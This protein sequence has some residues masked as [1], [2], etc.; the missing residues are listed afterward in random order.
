MN[1][2][3]EVAPLTDVDCSL[4]QGWKTKKKSSASGARS[5]SATHTTE[6]LD[7]LQSRQDGGYE[8]DSTTSVGEGHASTPADGVKQ[9]LDAEPPIYTPPPRPFHVCSSRVLPDVHQGTRYPVGRTS[10]L[11]RDGAGHQRATVDA[12]GA[13]RAVL[14]TSTR[15]TTISGKRSLPENF[16]C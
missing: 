5:S 7:D 10:V 2:P 16:V 15:D 4:V 1:H 8:S 14:Q 3:R 9:D 6:E 11:D 12:I 13:G